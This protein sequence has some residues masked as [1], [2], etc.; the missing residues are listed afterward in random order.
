MKDKSL[1]KVLVIGSGPIVIGQAAE[2]DYA[3]VQACRALREEK[4]EIVL[5]NSNPATIMT[6]EEIADKVYIEPLTLESLTEIIKKELPQGII[7]TLG[8]QTGLNLAVELDNAG[9]LQEYNV[10]LLGTNIESIKKAE[11]REMFKNLMQEI[12]EPVPDSMIVSS[13]EEAK[14]FSEKI[15]FPI[16]IRPAFT[17]GGSGGGIAHNESEYE[18]IVHSGLVQSPINQVLVEKSIAGYKEIEYEV[19]RDSNDTCIIICNMENIDPIGIHTGDSFVVAPS[20][21]LTNNEYQMLR[22]SAIKIIRALKIEGGCNVQFAL[23]TV[24]NQ[25]YVIEVN[26]RVSRSSALASKATGY[27]IAKISTKIAIGYNLYE[28]KNAITGKT[29]A[30]EPALDYV[31]VKI[32]KWPFDKFATGDRILGTKMKATGEIMAIGRTFVSAFKKAVT[33]LEERYTGLLHRNFDEMPNE[34][35]LQELY[36]QDDRRIFR[37]AQALYNGAEVSRLCAITKIDKWFISKI[38]EIVEMERELTKRII[39]KDLYIKAKEFGFL[40]KEIANITGSS[41]EKLKGFE[42]DASFRLVDTCAAE[43]SASTPYFYS[44]YSEADEVIEYK[45]KSQKN[46]KNKRENVLVLGSGP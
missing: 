12:N 10:R 24:S 1:K 45:E 38:K 43:F 18:E 20:Q 30:F 15:G 37:L 6:D 41:L 17:L 35:L 13:Y 33:S 2:F 31:T 11:D 23:D 7:A 39:D 27:P 5:V 8:G 3:G 14:N 42:V 40:D 29:A 46:Y 21:T 19:M 34:E 25:Y 28:I 36:I 26:P 22:S 9:V 16:I 4:I 44:T 32:P